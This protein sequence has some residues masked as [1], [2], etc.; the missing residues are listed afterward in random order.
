MNETKKCARCGDVLPLSFFPKINKSY[1]N[2]CRSIYQ[3]EYK[4]KNKEKLKEC[5]KLYKEKN[6][7]KYKKL[8]SMN[9]ERNK[10]Y[11]RNETKILS[12]NY[13]KKLLKTSNA[14]MELI[15]AKRIQ[16]KIFRE[17]RYKT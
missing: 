8:A 2:K 17:C 16:I 10:E 4:E 13:I 3:K 6:K 14:P 5:Y 12:D 11:Y 15:E 9:Y 7:E 1:C